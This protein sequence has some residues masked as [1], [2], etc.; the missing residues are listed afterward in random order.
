MSFFLFSEEGYNTIVKDM[1]RDLQEFVKDRAEK[2][3]ETDLYME[4]V[5]D[6]K[7]KLTKY[8]V[9]DKCRDLR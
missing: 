3:L 4:Q 8:Q 5:V 6:S 7:E 1:K 2:V 9:V